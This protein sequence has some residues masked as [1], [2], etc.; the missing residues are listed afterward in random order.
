M[1][2][3]SRPALELTM[4][5]R[6]VLSCLFL[7]AIL[8]AAEARV[9]MPS[10]F[11]DN[12]VLQ[13]N[14]DAAFWGKAEP[15]ASVSVSVSWSDE[16]VSCTADALGKWFLRVSTP[17]AGGPY[18]I[19]VS[20]HDE[21]IFRNVLIGEVWICAGQSN[22]EM[23]MKGFLGQPVN[24]SAEYI[25]GATPDVPV[26]CCNLKRIKSLE[27]EFDCPAVWYEHT[28]EGVS[29][30][31]ATAYFFARRLNEVLG[32]PIGVINVSWGGTPIEAWMDLDLIKEDF[33]DEFDLSSYENGEFRKD[34]PHRVAGVLYNGMMHSIIPFTAKG[35]VWYQGCDN[36]Y[37]FEQYMRLQP[38]F[39]AM[40]R[41]QWGD[42]DMPFYFTQIAPYRYDDPELRTA[43]YM[44]WAQARTLSMIP[45]SGMATTHDIGEFACIHPAEKKSVSDMLAG[46]ALAND[47]G[48]GG[49]EAQAPVFSGASFKEN[50]AHVTFDVGDMGLSPVN[51][52]LPGFELAGEDHVFYPA[53]ARICRDCRSIDVTSPHV[54]RPVAVRYGMKNWSEATLYNCFGLPASP[55]RSDDWE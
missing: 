44:M 2:P 16:K 6:F 18:E 41:E 13:Q 27:E 53:T 31:S 48:V 11:S 43:G 37:R 52:D 51:M 54:S 47:Y 23:Q 50:T 33:P 45:N 21:T 22:M 42:D 30:A 8:T 17:D 46:L 36:R 9:T 19:T 12:M 3:R 38:A 35:F 40:L 29:E 7:A 10:V 39:A 4:F 32:V 20:D 1:L 28:P 26:R 49:F 55:F 24:N 5:R 14:S 25:S 34:A 15:G